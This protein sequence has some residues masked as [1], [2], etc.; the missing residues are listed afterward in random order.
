MR[1]YR[2]WRYWDPDRMHL[3][4]AGHQRMAIEVLDTL[5]VDHDLDAAPAGRPSRR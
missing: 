1:E 3:G 2:D 4:P 5:G